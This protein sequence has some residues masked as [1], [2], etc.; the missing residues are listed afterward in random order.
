MVQGTKV[1][2]GGVFR[3]F[4][5]DKVVLLIQIRKGRPSEIRAQLVQ[6]NQ[7]KKFDFHFQ[8]R[9]TRIITTCNIN[10]SM[11]DI[12]HKWSWEMSR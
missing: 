7:G 10:V 12:G 4:I 6:K 11:G 5:E 8:I 3:D 2:G 9:K 1:P